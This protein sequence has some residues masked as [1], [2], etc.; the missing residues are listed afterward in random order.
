MSWHWFNW[1]VLAFYFLAMVGIGVYFS[2]KNSST[3]DYF[4]ASG[5]IPSWV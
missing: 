3:E 5:R 1:V 2:K 4:T